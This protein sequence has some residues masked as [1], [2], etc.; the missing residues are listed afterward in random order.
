MSMGGGELDS[1]SGSESDQSK[2]AVVLVKPEV[3]GEEEVEKG[4]SARKGFRERRRVVDDIKDPI[5]DAIAGVG[6]GE[7]DCRWQ[8]VKTRLFHCK[9]TAGPLNCKA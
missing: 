3:G 5:R 8:L 6:F 9:L 7:S 1:D 2:E 4:R